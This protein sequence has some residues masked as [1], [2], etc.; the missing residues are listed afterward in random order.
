MRND[1]APGGQ[2]LCPP[3]WHVPTKNDWNV[4]FTYYNGQSRAGVKVT[5]SFI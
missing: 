5:E 3:G 1:S 4:L 2:G